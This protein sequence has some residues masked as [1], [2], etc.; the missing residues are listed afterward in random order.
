MHLTFPSDVVHVRWYGNVFRSLASFWS[1][2][3]EL[4]KMA[5]EKEWYIKTKVS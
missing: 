2:Q 5:G 3:S 1:M 4:T